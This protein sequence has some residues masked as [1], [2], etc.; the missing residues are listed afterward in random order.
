MDI[1]ENIV[2]KMFGKLRSSQGRKEAVR[3][4]RITNKMFYMFN[5]KNNKG[6]KIKY[7]QHT[8]CKHVWFLYKEIYTQMQDFIRNIQNDELTACIKYDVA[9]SRFL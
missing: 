2:W 1:L 8:M 5:L 7:V 6:S 9:T 4:T 3:E